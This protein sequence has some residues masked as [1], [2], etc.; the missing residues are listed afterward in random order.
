MALSAHVE[1]LPRILWPD[2]R[3][4]AAYDVVIVG[5][6]G[7]GLST[8]WHLAT[9]HGITNVAVLEGDYLAS[10]NTGRNTTIIRSNYALPEAVR[11]YD[12]SLRLY[13]RFQDDVGADIVHRTK[14]HIWLAH[15][16]LALRTERSRS[17]MNLAMGVETVMVT[18]AEVKELVPQIDLTGGGRYPILGASFHKPAA[19]CSRSGITARSCCRACR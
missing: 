15:T 10:G 14:G 5:G 19:T 13:E 1:S 16:E 3:P 2:D 9:R 17:L 4:K 6:G 11:F 18:P 12:R 7:H 8:A